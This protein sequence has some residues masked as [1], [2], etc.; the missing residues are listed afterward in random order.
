MPAGSFLK[1]WFL[2]KLAKLQTHIKTIFSPLKLVVQQLCK[3]CNGV[4]SFNFKVQY[5]RKGHVGWFLNML[6][7]MKKG[8]L[9]TVTLKF[10]HSFIWQKWL[11]TL[12]HLLHQINKYK[13]WKYWFT[14][15]KKKC[16]AFTKQKTYNTMTY[17]TI[18]L[19]TRQTLQ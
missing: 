3:F 11:T 7:A 14:L 2:E 6:L 9:Y 13:I 1:L 19:A 5:V 17:K 8:A 12:S 4:S 16:L 18:G 15:I 10:I